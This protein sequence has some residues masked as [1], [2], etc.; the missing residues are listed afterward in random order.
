MSATYATRALRIIRLTSLHPIP[1]TDL[2][3]ARAPIP[4]HGRGHARCR[5]RPCAVAA[6]Q[7]FVKAYY[8]S[9]DA[10]VEAFLRGSIQK[11]TPRQLTKCAVRPVHG[12]PR[13]PALMACLRCSLINFGLNPAISKKSRQRL[14]ELVEELVRRR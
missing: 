2:A 12:R 5:D 4:R 3:E 6:A 8:L 1:F 11:Y 7:G 13:C 14:V 9:T 10:D